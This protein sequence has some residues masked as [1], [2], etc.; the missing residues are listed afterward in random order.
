MKIKL[1]LIFGFVWF[2]LVLFGCCEPH[3]TKPDEY[4]VFK[5][6]KTN[7]V[8]YCTVTGKDISYWINLDRESAKCKEIV[9][10]G[11]FK[12]EFIEVK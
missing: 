2:C 8:L 4:T 5:S 9:D 6:L 1:L 3:H 7:E 11:E 12:L 10:S